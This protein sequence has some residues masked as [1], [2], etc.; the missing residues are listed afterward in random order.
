MWKCVFLKQVY[1]WF[2]LIKYCTLYICEIGWEG[3]FLG[4][5]YLWFQ[6]NCL[7]I[8]QLNRL[9]A[10]NLTNIPT[11][12]NKTQYNA[13]IPHTIDFYTD[14]VMRCSLNYYSLSKSDA[15]NLTNIPTTHNKTQYISRYSITHLQCNILYTIQ[16]YSY[17]V[18]HFS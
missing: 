9:T 16:Y 12:R 2:Y 10:N 18:F 14:S 7:L 13:I 5:V 8:G 15:N 17:H 6:F 1:L 3:V 4:Q 11:A